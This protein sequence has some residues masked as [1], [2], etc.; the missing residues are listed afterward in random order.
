MSSILAA[1][2][3]IKGQSKYGCLFLYFFIIILLIYKALLNYFD[4]EYKQKI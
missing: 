2:A 3:I 1:G 4:I